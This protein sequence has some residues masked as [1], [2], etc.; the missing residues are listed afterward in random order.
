[1][2]TAKDKRSQSF[3]SSDS[4]VHTAAAFT[5]SVDKG[6]TGVKGRVST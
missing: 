1:M 5:V 2:E 3:G 4:M 6:G